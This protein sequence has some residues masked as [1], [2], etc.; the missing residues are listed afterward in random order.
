MVI[1]QKPAT[2]SN[3]GKYKRR[4][5]AMLFVYTIPGLLWG[6]LGLGL[7]VLT[8]FISKSLGAALLVMGILWLIIGRKRTDS[9]GKI[10]KA[11]RIYFI[12]LFVYGIIALVLSPLM[13]WA[14]WG[15]RSTP[16]D[17]RA[18]FIKRDLQQLD[19]KQTGGDE[20]LSKSLLD[21]L[22]DS[23]NPEIEPQ[24]FSVFTKAD[25]DKLLVLVKV[26]NLTKIEKKSRPV[27]LKII[28]DYFQSN[29]EY[30]NKRL[31]IGVQGRVLL[32][33]VKTPEQ[34]QSKSLV[35]ER[36]LYT[37]YAPEPVVIKEKKAIGVH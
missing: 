34:D 21:Y 28:E 32:G 18:A 8:Y 6:A 3:A 4:S 11:P 22:V 14:E 25:Q 5:Q 2:I 24:S 31:Y 15:A 17:Q 27:L 12:P 1:L 10:I 26:P 19:E 7:G 20:S 33:L 30:S 35:L 37:F 16:V 23:I 29:A 13:F 36:Y 9:E